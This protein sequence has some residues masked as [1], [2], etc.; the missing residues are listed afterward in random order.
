MTYSTHAIILRRRD[1]GEWDRL[2][3]V[4]TRER[5][6]V[7]LIGKGTRRPKA[8]LASHLEPFS[9]VDLVIAVGRAIDRVTFARAFQS[10]AAIAESLERATCASFLVECIDRLVVEPHRDP[11]IFDLLRAALS[12]IARSPHGDAAI[13]SDGTPVVSHA[14]TTPFLLRLLS[15]LG[16]A[17]QLDRCVECRAAIP[18]GKTIGVPARGGIACKKCATSIR[19]GI[20]L[21]ADDHRAIGDAIASF[22]PFSPSLATTTFATALLESHMWQPLRTSPDMTMLTRA[23]DPATVAAS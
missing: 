16:Y 17:P 13:S 6:K 7:M 14:L 1:H 4:Y 20:P 5:G 22:R 9:E 10:H 15:I 19:N 8:K 23:I 11:A 3:T 21:T 18:P 2:Y 12:V